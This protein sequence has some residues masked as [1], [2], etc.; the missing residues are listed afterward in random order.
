LIGS[1]LR[2]VER[3]TGRVIGALGLLIAAA[4]L[5]S[6]VV[7]PKADGRLVIGDALHHYVQLR[8][9]VF[10][11]DLNFRNE[12]VR[13][14]RLQGNEPGTE[15]VYENTPTGHVRNYMPVGPA[16]LWAPLFLLVSGV[17][18]VA[19][20]FGAGW[21]LDG[22]ARMYQATAGVSGVAAATA[23][24]WLSWRLTAQMFG[25]RAAAWSVLVLWLSS[26]AIY[27]S[28]ISPTYSHAASLLASS[29]FWYVFVKGRDWGGFQRY[30]ALGALTGAA[31]LMRWQ[32]VILF[33]PLVLQLA[34]DLRSGRLS[35]RDAV[36]SAVI[37]S[38]AA[39]VVFSPQMI[40]W[41]ALYGRPLA[42]PQGPEF[43]RWTNP[44]LIPML[45]S[46][47]HGLFT[48]TP[49]VAISIVGF[50]PLWR[51]DRV[52]AAAALSFFLLSWYVNAAVADWWAGEAYGARRFVSCFPV[53]AVALAALIERWAP[54]ARA[55]AIAGAVVAG[56]SLLLL[57]QYQA[58]M[59]GLRQIAPYPE[60]FFNL[61]LAR[62]V[63]PFRLA[64][65][66]LG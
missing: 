45:F 49:I 25:P 3:R 55:V 7:F 47:W 46:D 27:Y 35:L 34:W 21:P 53:F 18:F 4:Y 65:E 8:S 44:A 15:W 20:Q 30:A 1:L 43:M 2:L 48:W 64:R 32:D 57:V 50:V 26:S 40:V 23:G 62:F 38:V 13:L 11:H 37:A 14:Y 19:N 6:I 33:V 24:V 10:D 54:G 58:F 61:W 59:H 22:Y 9:A 31:A 39:A 51:R 28:L 12:Y 60:G 63:V 56:Y 17:A 36:A 5:A 52:T 29:A 66:W 16:V 41:R 42:L